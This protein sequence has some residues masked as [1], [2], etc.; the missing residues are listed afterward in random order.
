MLLSIDSMRS[1]TDTSGLCGLSITISSV[2]S[3]ASGASSVTCSSVVVGAGSVLTVAVGGTSE[4]ADDSVAA[5]GSAVASGLAVFV[6]TNMSTIDLSAEKQPGLHC[7]RH[8]Q[9]D[10]RTSSASLAVSKI[11]NFSGSHFGKKP[12]TCVPEW[13]PL[14]TD[15]TWSMSIP[16]L[17]CSR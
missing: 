14:I 1:T 7:S 17:P 16:R 4:A 3:L 13:R 2:V 6:L 10:R 15:D 5:D 9:L 8:H 12:S 11:L